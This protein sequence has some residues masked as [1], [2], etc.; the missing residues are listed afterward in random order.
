LRVVSGVTGKFNMNYTSGLL[1]K[2]M[3]FVSVMR[4][5]QNNQKIYYRK[6]L[7]R[8]LTRWGVSG[9]KVHLK[10]GSGEFL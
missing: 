7:S 10:V 8:S 9:V 4:G 2:C 3:A 5:I 1:Q 6:D